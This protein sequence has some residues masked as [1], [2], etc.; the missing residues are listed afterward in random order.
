MIRIKDIAE[1]AGVSPTTVS[2]VLHGNKGRVSKE[3]VEKIQRIMDEMHYIPSI[4]A[5]MLA[6]EHSGLI[7]VVI[8]YIKKGDAFA[9]EDPFVAALVGNL[10]YQIR[11]RGYYMMLLTRHDRKEMLGQVMG[12]NFDGLITIGLLPREMRQIQE[13]FGKPMIAIDSYEQLPDGIVNIGTDDRD[14]GYQ[15]GSYLAR[16]GHRRILFLADNDMFLDHERW[17]GVRE[18]LLENNITDVENCHFIIDGDPVRRERQYQEQFPFL[19]S[20]TA[21]FFASDFYA[22]EAS[23]FF[24]SRG[25]LVPDQLSIAG[26]DDVSYAKMARPGLTTIRQ[27]VD[28]KARYAVEAVMGMLE[29]K[30]VP[31]EYRVATSLVE[32]ESVC[33]LDD[34]ELWKA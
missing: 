8:G 6:R 11:E 9:L 21:L 4:S 7:G 10:E 12:W 30:K 29:G 19:T 23:N 22:V 2:N 16:L 5:Q 27:N 28:L 1:R 26:F 20:R 13:M 24:Q 34:G 18:A 31:Q 14:G 3:N 33:S 32:R 17:L 15:M 25:I